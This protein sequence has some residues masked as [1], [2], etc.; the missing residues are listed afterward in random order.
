MFW[1]SVKLAKG[2]YLRCQFVV[3][4]TEIIVVV[5]VYLS[6]IRLETVNNM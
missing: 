5:F 4:V 6:T 3:L 1:N 2:I